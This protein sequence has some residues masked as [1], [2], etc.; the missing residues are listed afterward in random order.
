M[1]V[2]LFST[3]F[4]RY[5]PGLDAGFPTAE[6]ETKAEGAGAAVR[7]GR[8]GQVEPNA[9]SQV[10]ELH[11][12]ARRLS[13]SQLE[14]HCTEEQYWYRS[15][16]VVRNGRVNLLNDKRPSVVQVPRPKVASKERTHDYVWV[17][18]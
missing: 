10:F 17:R 18:S 14:R 2:L 16:S 11:Q 9:Q 6:V 15:V 8:V 13:R 1:R 5:G 4:E 7:R 3:A 12:I